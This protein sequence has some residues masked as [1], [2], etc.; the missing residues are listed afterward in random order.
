MAIVAPSGYGKTI[1]GYQLYKASKGINFYSPS[2]CARYL[3]NL[4][5]VSVVD[6]PSVFINI[7]EAIKN[8]SYGVSILLCQSKEDLEGLIDIPCNEFINIDAWNNDDQVIKR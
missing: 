6:E 8:I 1:L 2:N 5:G 4:S 7:N 3:P